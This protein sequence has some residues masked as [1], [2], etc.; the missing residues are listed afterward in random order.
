MGFLKR[1]ST[2]KCGRSEKRQQQQQQ[3]AT[4]QISNKLA[5]SQ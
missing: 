4:T 5:P 1:A 2:K 3:Q